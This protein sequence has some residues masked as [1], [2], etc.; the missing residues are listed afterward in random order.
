MAWDREKERKAGASY[1]IAMN[2][3]VLLFGIVWCV[4]VAST[5]VWFMLLF[6][7]FFVGMAAYRLIMCVKVANSEKEKKA[8]DPWDR[9]AGQ[10]SYQ[11]E[12]PRQAPQ[13]GGSGY[14]PYCGSAIQPGFEF[15]PK[16]GR[17]LP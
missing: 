1:S 10:Q 8:A 13:S 9:P 14:C 16:C 4:L 3:F 5:G 7:L 6:G 11:S 12:P 17:R 15:C 2:I